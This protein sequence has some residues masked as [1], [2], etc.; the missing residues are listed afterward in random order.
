MMKQARHTQRSSAYY[1]AVIIGAGAA[2]LGAARTLI[3]G[4]AKV[5]VLEARDRVGGRAF[6][7]N[8][9]FPVPVD[10]G[11]QWFH[12]G[13]TN[14]LRVIAQQAGYQTIHDSFPRLVYEGNKQLPLDDPRVLEFGTLAVT[15]DELI[16]E[17]GT[18]V[19]A[20]NSPDGP[21]SE[22][23]AD[24]KL[25]EYYGMAS[26]AVNVFSSTMEDLS[27]LDFANFYNRALLPVSSGGGDE[28]FIPYGMGN[29]IA[30]FADGVRVELL[31]PV[32]EIWWGQPSGVLI[33]TASGTVIRAKTTIITAP[34]AV[35]AKGAIDFKPSLDSAYTD[36]FSGLKMDTLSK[37]FLQFNSNVNF[38]VPNINSVC[39][40]LTPDDPEAPAPAEVPFIITKIY[41]ENIAMLF[42]MGTL[43]HRLETE[44]E[45]AMLDYSLTKMAKMFDTPINR[46]NL[47]AMS[48]HS[49]LKDEWS[50]GCVSYAPPG[51]V[52]LRQTL[53]RP[54][55]NQLF[56][57]G[58]AVSLYAHSSVHGAYETGTTAARQILKLL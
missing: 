51:A 23:I 31:T 43:A 14:S 16:E 28:F 27:V 25:S 8:T 19:A 38:N 58:E 24:C 49:W 9:S 40:P 39:V 15:M 53:A 47:V 50:L 29:F 34:V 44:G 2:G 45:E 10:L 11:A 57:A 21:A 6:C 12:Q 48:H 13:F 22:V 33:K 4:G 5:I 42:V 7:D 37:F 18:S 54:I 3:Q 1:D 35:L 41:G 17:A 20:G 56:F 36:A 30:D 52:P 55:N 32:K 46:D 26:T